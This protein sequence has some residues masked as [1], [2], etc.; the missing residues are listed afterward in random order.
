MRAIFAG[1]FMIIFHS[2]WTIQDVMMQTH[3]KIALAEVL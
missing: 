2:I 1:K 3:N